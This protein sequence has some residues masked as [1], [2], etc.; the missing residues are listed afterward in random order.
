MLALQNAD[1]MHQHALYCCCKRE[2]YVIAG[3]GSAGLLFMQGF[4]LCC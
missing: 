1:V 2:L 3:L 4:V